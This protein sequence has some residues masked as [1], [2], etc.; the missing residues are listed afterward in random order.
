MRHLLVLTVLVAAVALAG[1]TE[2]TPGAAVPGDDTTSTTGTDGTTGTDETSSESPPSTEPSGTN[3]SGLADVDPC[4]L[5]PADA[6]QTLQ[7][8]GG[9]A[10][11]LGEA[12][13][14]RW[15]HDGATL[16]ESFTVSVEIF[17]TLGLADLVGTNIQQLPKIGSHDATSSVG[18]TG[19]CAV[20]LG[21]GPSS[22]VDNTAVGG[23][24]QL[25]CQLVAQLAPV[26]E[27][28]LP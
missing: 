7:L 17:E 18:P 13:V 3:E 6:L 12:R 22:R 14:C 4:T 24:L 11:T 21:V 23:D 8:T 10:K 16:N 28:E 25:A 26:V 2:K 1:C 20:S 19:G 15:R 27:P 5:V 9:E